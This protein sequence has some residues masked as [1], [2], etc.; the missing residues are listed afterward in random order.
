MEDVTV[1]EVVGE[2]QVAEL[3]D[4]EVPRD[5]PSDVDGRETEKRQK[6]GPPEDGRADRQPADRGEDARTARLRPGCTLGR[7]SGTA[8]RAAAGGGPGRHG[9]FITARPPRA[10]G[11]MRHGL[12]PPAPPGYHSG[13]GAG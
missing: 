2:G 7:A 4:G 8:P 5:L 1:Q 9:R 13:G 11:K 6:S 10:R 12:A 3:V